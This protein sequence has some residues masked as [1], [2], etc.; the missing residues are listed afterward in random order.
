[1]CVYGEQDVRVHRVASC[2]LGV[3]VR[4]RGIEEGNY[5]SVVYPLILVFFLSSEVLRDVT[6]DEV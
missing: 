3:D 4:K 5:C 6:H 2:T 1:M